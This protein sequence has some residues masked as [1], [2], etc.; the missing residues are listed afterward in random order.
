MQ[1]FGTEN[2]RLGVAVV[3][4][5]GAVATTA[6]A[7]VEL[8]R[9]GA[10]GTEGLPLAGFGGLAPYENLVFGGWDLCGDDLASA[11]A[12]NGVLSGE[13][14]RVTKPRLAD[15]RPWP[16]VVN[17]GFCRNASGTHCVSADDHRGAHGDHPGRPAAL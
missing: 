16:A 9:Q 12:S 8:I 6:A 5:G 15:I 13:Q 14:L 7:G 3:G 17:P 11:A 4:L 10:T 2:R 1:D